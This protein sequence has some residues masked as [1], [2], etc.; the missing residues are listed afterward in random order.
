[1]HVKVLILFG[2]LLKIVWKK[3]LF[4]AKCER[5]CRKF[6]LKGLLFRVKFLI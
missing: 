3:F 6:N 4:F 5:K 1:M 2:L